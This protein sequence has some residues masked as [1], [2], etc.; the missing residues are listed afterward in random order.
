MRE[1]SR[2]ISEEDLLA[3]L[4][5]VFKHILLTGKAGSGKTQLA[6]NFTM[7]Y[8][9]RIIFRSGINQSIDKT[10]KQDLN[11]MKK[12]IEQRKTLG[13]DTISKEFLI[14]DEGQRC[15]ETLAE[16]EDFSEI[17]NDGESVGIYI[18]LISQRAEVLREIPESSLSKFTIIDLG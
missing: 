14:I 12:Q 10:L 16:S 4:D 7:K 18:I 15:A 9:D 11:L 17:L 5:G 1:K 3:K 8:G 2:F 13:G 6:K